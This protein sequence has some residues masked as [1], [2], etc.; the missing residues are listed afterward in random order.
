[1]AGLYSNAGAFFTFYA[2]IYMTF[3][4]LSAFFR[5]LGA[6]SFS[7]DTASRMARFV[8]FGLVSGLMFQEF[9]LVDFS[10]LPPLTK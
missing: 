2:L 10:T 4:A 7:F 1:M 5:L 6:I 9:D 8:K 3:L